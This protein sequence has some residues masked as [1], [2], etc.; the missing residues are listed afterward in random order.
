M[1]DKIFSIF[2]EISVTS[3]IDI[4]LMSAL[5]YAVLA[6]LKRKRAVFVLIGI[7]IF[8]LVFFLADQF[9]LSLT[10]SVLQGF[11]PV[12]LIALIVIFQEEFRS[13]FERIAVLSLRGKRQK[14]APPLTEIDIF[15]QALIELARKKI[16]AILVIK[17]KDMIGRYLEGG[18]ELSGKISEPILMSIFDPHSQGHDGAMVIDNQQI[19]RFGCHLPLSKNLDKIWKKGTRHAAALGLTEKCDA[20]CLVVSEEQGKVSAAHRS[21][22]FEIRNADH[23]REVL[24]DFYQ[25]TMPPSHRRTWKDFFKRNYSEKI[26]A[27]MISLILWFMV[28][29]ESKYTIKSFKV[30]VEYFQVA[31]HLSVKE[32]RPDE[33]VA[34]FS[35]PRN[36]FHLLS[37][38]DVRLTL[39]ISS[40]QEG[41]ETI[42][43]S[44]SDFSFP[45]EINLEDIE[46]HSVKVT[47]VKK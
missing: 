13:F 14:T 16:G 36:A 39:K 10:T 23:L 9:N 46:P 19:L 26:A 15:V 42:S 6:W 38:K 27:V 17:G 40:T 47:L 20:L 32:I 2:K 30:P 7:L 3:L 45:K 25:E 34:T 43:L 37:E 4:G 21:E 18:F 28:V 24:K 44:K 22:I 11:F 35:A 41:D 33:V 8:G 31:P 12:L 29:H 5:I 1:S